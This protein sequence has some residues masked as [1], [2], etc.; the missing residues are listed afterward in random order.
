MPK[1]RIPVVYREARLRG[2]LPP[3]A[4]RVAFS[5]DLADGTVAR[6]CLP[7]EDVETLHS[8]I[9]SQSRGSAGMPSRDE[10]SARNALVNFLFCVAGVHRSGT[11][12]ARA[13]RPAS[14]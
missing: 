3:E 4:G 9:G 5:F 13:G 14:P 12:A 7:I 2:V 8:L 1:S 6:L 10:T 11:G